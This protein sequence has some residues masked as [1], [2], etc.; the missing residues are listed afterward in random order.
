MSFVPTKCLDDK[1]EI[2]IKIAVQNARRLPGGRSEDVLAIR[3]LP[4]RVEQIPKIAAGLSIAKLRVSACRRQPPLPAME[5]RSARPVVP[6]RRGRVRLAA[7][8]KGRESRSRR[9]EMQSASHT[10]S[11]HS[12]RAVRSPRAPCG[13]TA[14]RSGGPERDEP[15][16]NRLS[17]LR[18]S[19]RRG[20]DP[21][22]ITSA[23]ATRLYVSGFLI[24]T[25]GGVQLS[26]VDTR[27]CDL[28]TR[29]VLWM[30]C[31][32]PTHRRYRTQMDTPLNELIFKKIYRQS[33]NWPRVS[34][35]FPIL[36]V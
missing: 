23:N 14:W 25:K 29:S 24:L 36:K 35:A 30:V 15:G 12:R 8:A 11:S 9:G 27:Y 7:V 3:Q 5:A 1:Y 13:R 2:Y 18:E 31:R 17:P 32:D 19:R 22:G 6:G 20:I 26:A 16:R 4:I 34:R 21:P 33:A 10:P 28:G